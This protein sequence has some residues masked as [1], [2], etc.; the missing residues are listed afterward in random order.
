MP[1]HDPARPPHHSTASRRAA[2]SAALD[3]RTGPP[4]LTTAPDLAAPEGAP[5]AYL[6]RRTGQALIV[7]ALAFTVTFVLLQ[8]LPGD[9]ILIK[10]ESPELGLSPEQIAGIRASYGADVPPLQQ[11]LHTVLGF[12]QGD[13][14]YSVQ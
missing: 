13:F 11:Y 7:L 2:R 8:A 12:V 10:F 9:A 3:H 6:A 1:G 5:M 4:H 14:G